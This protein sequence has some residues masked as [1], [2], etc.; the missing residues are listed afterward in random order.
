MRARSPVCGHDPMAGIG[1]LKPSN[2]RMPS[3]A[4]ALLLFVLLSGCL[5]G[6]VTGADPQL[7]NPLRCNNTNPSENTC[8]SYLYVAADS[9]RS[10][11]QVV[12]PY[13]ISTNNVFNPPW[14]DNFYLLEVD[15]SCEVYNTTLVAYFA[16][17]AYTVTASDKDL[18]DISHR[19]FNDFV[20]IPANPP[21]LTPGN[22]TGIE[23]VC[24][25]PN[26]VPG[27]DVQLQ[28]AIAT[29]IVQKGDTLFQVANTFHADQR[30]T[31]DINNI[32]NSDLLYSSQ[33]LFIPLNFKPSVIADGTSAPGPGVAVRAQ[34]HGGNMIGLVAGCVVAGVVTL[35]LIILLIT[36]ILFRLQ[37]QK[38][39]CSDRASYNNVVLSGSTRSYLSSSETVR[40]NRFLNLGSVF[41]RCAAIGGH[42]GCSVNN[43]VKRSITLPREA[44]SVFDQ[45]K[46]IVFHY[47][48]IIAATH[49]FIE[50]KR[51]GQGAFGTVYRGTLRHQEVAIKQMK[52]TKSKEF[53][54]ELKVLCKVHHTNLVELIG[55]SA[56]E[57]SLF[58]VYEFAENGSLSDHLHDP[59]SKGNVPLTWT[60]R[61]QIALDAARGLEY[62]HEHTKTHYVHRDVKTRN[63]LLDSYFRAK[64]ADFGLDKLIEHRDEFTDMIAT[65]SISGTY[66]YLA[67]EYV[68]DGL[69]TS[70][71][72]V[73]AFG[74]VL[75]E[76]IT[77]REALP[78]TKPGSSSHSPYHRQSL[79]S[80]MLEVL[81]PEPDD[82]TKTKKFRSCVDPNLDG[83][84]SF[85][86]SYKLAQLGKACVDEDAGSRPDMKQIVFTLS[87]NLLTTIEWEA[88]LAGSSQIFSGLVQGR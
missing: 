12:G 38:R 18:A 83:N 78:I 8:K 77:G 71:S 17:K 47:E 60:A 23:L 76:L 16:K 58:L 36:L 50:T 68:R 55:Y 35:L 27:V 19:L 41:S 24:G 63:I 5:S 21:P 14:T 42:R 67:P 20:F 65:A 62:I 85:D 33:N 84:Y 57:E 66:G 72:D 46:P 39:A 28:Q 69:A 48:E 59:V 34:S 73:Y 13:S 80:S 37:E 10:V 79:I 49:K 32:T 30:L 40:S 26:S 2:T 56:G 88:A 70:K 31:M 9:S 61:V 75:F 22:Q 53:L 51:L 87:Q 7:I 11:E 25:C 29:Y 6:P 54:A 15:C 86:A 52:A 45:E 82:V 1:M 4:L 74:V 43:N 44:M 3:D 64:L 81:D